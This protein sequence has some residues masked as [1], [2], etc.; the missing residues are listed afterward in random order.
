MRQRRLR[1]RRIEPP[2]PAPLPAVPGWRSEEQGVVALEIVAAADIDPR[3]RMGSRRGP[4]ERISRIPGLPLR[5]T[6]VPWR[7]QGGIVRT[8]PQAEASRV[9]DLPRPGLDLDLGPQ[10]L[11]QG[12]AV[13]ISLRPRADACTAHATSASGAAIIRRMVG[14]RGAPGK[15]I[16]T[17][18]NC[19]FAGKIP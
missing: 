11:A 6:S 19:L 3:R 4:A 15:N 1:P 13:R 17:Q 8:D 10:H 2:A 12:E 16:E 9:G 7:S 14:Q 18:S 5:K